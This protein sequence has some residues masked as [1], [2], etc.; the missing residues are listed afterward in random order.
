MVPLPPET[1]KEIFEFLQDDLSTLYLCMQVDKQWAKLVIEIL[2]RDTSKFQDQYFYKETGPNV[3]STLITCLSEN[4]KLILK[5]HGVAIPSTT[6]PPMFDYA[7]FCRNLHISHLNYLIDSFTLR[8]KGNKIS[9]NTGNRVKTYHL[10]LYSRYLIKQ[11]IYRIFVN[12]CQNLNTLEYRDKSVPLFFLSNAE[13][14]FSNLRELR[15]TTEMPASIFYRMTQIC[16][17]LESLI[18]EECHTDNDGLVT[19]IN[20]QNRLN[21]VKIKTKG[22]RLIENNTSND[23]YIRIINAL[24]NKSQSMV[25][26]H[27]GGNNL[28]TLSHE[29]IT[30]LVNL[31]TL[32][33]D[34]QEDWKM[35]FK[36]AI[37]PNLRVIEL[38]NPPRA[39]ELLTSFIERTGANLEIIYFAIP[40]VR[41]PLLTIPVFN[42]AVAKYCPNLR[43]L[44]TWF[45]KNDIEEFK[46]VLISCP[47]LENLTLAT[48]RTDPKR[49][50]ES[51][52]P[53]LNEVLEIIEKLEE[54]TQQ[55]LKLNKLELCWPWKID[56]D[57]L[58]N[59]LV[60]HKDPKELKS[61][62]FDPVCVKEFG[63]DFEDFLELKLRKFKAN[64]LIN[65]FG[66]KNYI[67]FSNNFVRSRD[68]LMVL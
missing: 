62:Y 68:G 37:F 14:C 54:S 59:F 33:I 7:K 1:L 57:I 46:E 8:F 56:I 6:R 61:F 41:K 34:F 16:R 38:R 39:L 23:S 52:D 67:R 51:Y 36:Y 30:K 50:D 25:H 22:R 29:D 60:K 63:C 4:S 45:H 5:E 20:I 15:T 3:I 17:N 24:S 26:F 27:I 58:E 31:Q 40:C 11:E 12:Q 64:G 55:K 47:K 48:Y 19:F 44:T 42:K 13:I 35:L 21:Y 28:G 49:C 65:D 53:H 9:C 66:I 43:C 2:W 10:N 18:I 32:I